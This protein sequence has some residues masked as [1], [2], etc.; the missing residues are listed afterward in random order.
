MSC[1]WPWEGKDLLWSDRGCWAKSPAQMISGERSWNLK[2][3]QA[4]S[5]EERGKGKK[6]MA[7]F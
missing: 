4:G 2:G 3:R 6:E 7:S 5:K 1:S